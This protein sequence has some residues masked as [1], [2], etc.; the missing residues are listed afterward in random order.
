VGL[1]LTVEKFYSPLGWAYSGVG[2]SP[3][4]AVE[5]EKRWSLARPVDGKLQIP[6]ITK[7]VSSDPN[8]PFIRQAIITAQK[9]VSKK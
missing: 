6:V 5:A 7:T 4:I 2:V 3:D 8:D 1:K 9:I